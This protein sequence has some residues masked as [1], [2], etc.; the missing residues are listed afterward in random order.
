MPI[1]DLGG[2]RAAHLAGTASCIV[3]VTNQS[4][5]QLAGQLAIEKCADVSPGPVRFSITVPASDTR[6]LLYEPLV[7]QAGVRGKVRLGAVSFR[8]ATAECA[9]HIGN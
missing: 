6:L 9:L 8:N 7:V 3:Q 4:L 1:E 2:S 5:S